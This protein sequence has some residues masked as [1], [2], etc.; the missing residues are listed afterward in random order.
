LAAALPE[1]PFA[2][3]LSTVE[4]LAG[5]VT[6]DSLVPAAGSIVLRDLTMDHELLERWQAPADREQWWRE[7]LIRCHRLLREA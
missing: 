4:L 7:R 5:D 2:C 6:D 1:L 3:G